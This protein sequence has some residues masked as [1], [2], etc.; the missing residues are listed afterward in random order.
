M[1][2]LREIAKFACGCEA[3]HA[4]MHFYFWVSG[5]TLIAFGIALTSKVNVF[6][7]ILGAAISVILGIYAWHPQDGD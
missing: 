7:A 1:D 3:F 5:T 4:A 6:S 2:R